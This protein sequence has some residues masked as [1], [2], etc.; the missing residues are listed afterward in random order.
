MAA[1]S[2]AVLAAIAEQRNQ[3]IHHLRAARALTPE[4]AI[5]LASLPSIG[6]G[7][8]ERLKKERVV[9]E[10]QQGDLY[11]DQALAAK[12]ESRRTRVTYTLVAMVVVFLGIVGIVV[13]MQ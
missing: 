11:L 7:I 6:S 2:T 3:F 1:G 13:L 8:L 5:A 12:L 10:N 9:L 4:T